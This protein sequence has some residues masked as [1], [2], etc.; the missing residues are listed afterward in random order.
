MLASQKSRCFPKVSIKKIFSK[1]SQ[2]QNLLILIALTKKKI[3]K[4]YKNKKK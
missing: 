1:T 2:A 4:K 3:I